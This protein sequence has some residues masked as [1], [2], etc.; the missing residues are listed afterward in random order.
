MFHFINCA[1]RQNF[2]ALGSLAVSLAVWPCRAEVALT[3]TPASSAPTAGEEIT[4]WVNVLNP[5]DAAE[6]WTFPLII[7]RKLISAQG[8]FTG[9]LQLRFAESNVVSIAPGN[10]VRREYIST[11]PATISGQVVME[12]SGVEINRTV[13]DVQNSG[14][15]AT[16]KTND[17]AFNRFIV[18]AEPTRSGQSFDPGHFFKEHISGYEPMYFIGG[19]KS[20]NIKFQ[21]SLAYQLLNTDGPLA[22]KVSALKGFHLAYTQSSLWDWNGD[23]APFYD[24]SYMPEFFYAWKNVTHT[25]HTNWFK[26]DLAGGLRHESN[27]KDGLDSRSLNVG[28]VRPTFTFGRDGNFQLMLQPRVWGYLGDLSDNAD[29]ADYRGY[30]DLRTVI[31][32]QRGLQLAVLGRM[33]KDGNHG[34]AQFDLTYPTMRFFGSFSLYLDLQYFNGYGESLLG[35]NEK[36]EV[37]RVG[38]ALFR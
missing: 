14:W 38:L 24:T 31:G 22:E 32:W 35:Y 30:A 27:G 15:T 4:L 29:I 10:F 23:S 21:I 28:Y 1:V 16:Q 19:T 20:P 37:L 12:F 2:V 7:E 33:G 5:T 3:V 13:L 34:S 26:L 18:E 8:N 6:A 11:L 17:S 25:A 36:T 9:T